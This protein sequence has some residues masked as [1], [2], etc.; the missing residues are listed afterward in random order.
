LKLIDSELK[1]PIPKVYVKVF[2]LFSNNSSKFY[3][4]GYTDL[5]GCFDYVSLNRDK[6]NDI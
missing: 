2:A 3:K 4:D 5:R 1:K 6:L